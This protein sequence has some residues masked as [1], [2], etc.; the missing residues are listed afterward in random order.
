MFPG[1]FLDFYGLYLK[2]IIVVLGS[3]IVVC[4]TVLQRILVLQSLSLS[5]P[6]TH[7]HLHAVIRQ[8]STSYIASF[9][10]RAK[11]VSTR[12]VCGSIESKVPGLCVHVRVGLE[13]RVSH[14]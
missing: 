2:K 7:T 13:P 1:Y 12:F 11:S 4:T 8:V 9:I 10:A 14:T 3:D 5:L 6:H